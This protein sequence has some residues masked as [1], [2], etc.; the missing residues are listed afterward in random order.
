M[1]INI[2]FFRKAVIAEINGAKVTHVY[3]LQKLLGA[4]VQEENPYVRYLLGV[5]NAD[6]SNMRSC[7]NLLEDIARIKCRL[8]ES[9]SVA[10]N[11]FQTEIFPDRVEI[12]HV[13][14]FDYGWKIW[15]CDLEFFE[16]AL[17]GWRE[18]LLLPDDQVNEINLE[19]P[20]RDYS[21]KLE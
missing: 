7:D 1:T 16:T 13:Q 10:G 2:R 3:R 4:N 14:F 5:L 21:Y 6:F 12:C 18:F 8:V 11:A 9:L 15:V 19:L 20:E 17:R